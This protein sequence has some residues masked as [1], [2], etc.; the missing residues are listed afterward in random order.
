MLIQ[1]IGDRTSTPQASLNESMKMLEEEGISIEM[2]VQLNVRQD[3]LETY[4]QNEIS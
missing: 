3:I 1:G 4:D 2:I